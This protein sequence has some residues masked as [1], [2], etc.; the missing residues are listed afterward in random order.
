VGEKD[1]G[2]SPRASDDAS[3][4]PSR[5]RW[6]RPGRFLRD[7][8]ILA[9]LILIASGAALLLL[10][11]SDDGLL[12]L[13]ELTIGQDA[14][15]T[16]KSPRAFAIADIETTARLRQEAVARVL[17]V[18]DLKTVL[19]GE[20]KE[21]IETAFANDAA[22][23]AIDGGTIKPEELAQQHRVRAQ[24][25][26]RTLQVFIDEDALIPLFKFADPDQ[27][28]DAAIMIAQS[29][30]ERRIVDDR[31]LLRLQAPDGI[32]LR[33]IEPDE[34]GEKE[35]T[36]RG[37]DDLMSIDQARAR[38]D[39]LVADLLKRLPAEQ[40]RAVSLLV[41]RLVQPNLVANRVET[42]RRVEAAKSAVKTVV[43]PIKPGETVLH[44]GQRVTERHL[45]IL[46]GIEK[47]LRA[48]SRVQAS[49]GSAL[50]IVLLVVVMYRFMVRGF[51][52]FEP[53]HRDLAFLASA[54]LIMLLLIWLGYKG[55]IW[56]SEAFPEL[57]ASAYRLALPVAAFTLLV[58]FVVGAEYGAA[59]AP[60]VALTA[61]W[62]MG[63]NLGYAAYALS[64]SIAAASVKTTEKPR[65]ALF[66]AGL[67]AAF[68]Q[69]CVASALAL[70]DS[71]F[72]IEDTGGEVA[73]AI[74]SGLVSALLAA[75][76]LPAVEA[77][78][79]YTTDLKLTD[80]AN[81][82]HPLLRELLVEAPGTYH[83]SIL[84]GT[85]A[86]AGTNAI[87]ANKLLARVGAYYHDIGKIK[88]PRAFE[89]NVQRSFVSMAPVDEARE[90]RMHVADGLE[91]AAKHRLG[92][93][94]LEIIAQHH[95]QTFVRS[96]FRRATEQGRAESAEFAYPGPKPI[97]KEAAVVMLADFVEVAT[98]DLAAEVALDVPKIEAE[99]RRV[100][101][102]V[103]ND[104]QLDQSEL[105]L[106]DIGRII[107]A[108]VL[109]LEDRLIRRGRLT[110]SQLPKVPPAQ[111]VRPPLGGELN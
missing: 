77:I 78:F 76:L 83:H 73:A 110:L 32:Q 9:I 33:I 24:E 62:M 53:S 45:F 65:T 103:L 91:L 23:R 107:K 7:L 6:L 57:S 47:E 22:L 43:I 88:N 30:Y 66:V 54:F 48:Q 37:Y 93:P 63:A 21:R 51:R 12:G 16:I 99:V 70:L 85:L 74:A 82:N 19:G 108:F 8:N 44:A 34:T 59:F 90:I 50:L 61:G 86:E 84:V 64:G 3:R 10:P 97:T 13:P 35:E 92:Q 14:P 55:V 105:T 29:L 25:F 100:I 18:Y 52:V 41:K 96:A 49:A 95:G 11:S 68:A 4:P 81:L 1:G 75:L 56:A 5:L 98:R 89:E 106:L 15:R 69:V 60:L 20:A 42:E 109:V 67:R 40:R 28:R 58:R 38:V 102:E 72:T 104:G 17:P 31:A 111:M 39:E 27:L 87:G 36:L 71:H 26:L 79:G 46:R 94:V 2:E 101:G 80:L